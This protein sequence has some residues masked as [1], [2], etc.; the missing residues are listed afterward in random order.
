[1]DR[2]ELIRQIQTEPLSDPK[3]KP[4]DLHLDR[5]EGLRI[6]WEDG[7]TSHFPLTVLR[8]SCPCATCRTKQEESRAANKGLS[9]NVLPP[10]ID[11]AVMFAD[12]H[13]VGNYAIQITWGDGHNTG[14]YDFRYLRAMCELRPKEENQAGT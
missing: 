12:A 6:V 10:G 3:F 11:R 1:M 2:D 5:R 8:K 13:L 7:R 14:I 9:L 4:K